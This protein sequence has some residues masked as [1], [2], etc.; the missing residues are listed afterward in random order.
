[1]RIVHISDT[2]NKLRWLS[3]PDGDVLVHSGDG[4][5][6][7]TLW[8]MRAFAGRLQ[9]L[10]HRHKLYV[11]GNHDG[12]LETNPELVQELF[13]SVAV[14][15]DKGIVIDGVVF[16]GFPWVPGVATNWNGFTVPYGSSELSKACEGIPQDVDVLITHGP[17]EGILDTRHHPGC[18]VL[19]RFLAY[20]EPREK[21]RHHLFGHD[22]SGYGKEFDEDTNI[23]HYNGSSVNSKYELANAPR[24]IDI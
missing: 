17:A 18:G 2:H 4:T 1:M 5:R 7:N 24:V 14:L 3:V 12:L 10:P 11:P 23:W 21:P 9:R 16:Y 6:R 22:H 19:R 15:I 20:M 8:E 13:G